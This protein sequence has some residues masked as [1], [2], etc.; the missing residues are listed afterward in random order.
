MSSVITVNHDPLSIIDYGSETGWWR[1]VTSLAGAGTETWKQMPV[2][3]NFT[4]SPN[5]AENSEVSEG[6]VKY[7]LSKSQDYMLKLV[8]LQRG[9]ALWNAFPDEVDNKLIQVVLE[10]NNIP[11]P[12]GTFEYMLTLLKMTKRPEVGPKKQPEL[13]FRFYKATADITLTP[14]DST[15]PLAEA[16][17]DETTIL[18]HP[19]GKYYGIDAFVK[20]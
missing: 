10:L 17:W 5:E 4:I 8:F 7:T 18:T 1:V 12:D 9:A 20:A 13:D 2:R 11:F 19:K 15:H 14:T 16:T 6:R 3:G